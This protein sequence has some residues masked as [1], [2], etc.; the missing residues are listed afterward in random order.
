MELVRP[1]PENPS[2]QTMADCRATEAELQEMI[3]NISKEPN[4]GLRFEAGVDLVRGL[5]KDASLEGIQFAIH[6]A[7]QL[8]SGNRKF[9][10][11][12]C[13][14]A[15]DQM[16]VDDFYY[17]EDVLGDTKVERICLSV[18]LVKQRSVRKWLLTSLVACA[19]H[20]VN[21]E[22]WAGR[23]EWF[24]RQAEGHVDWA[25]TVMGDINFKVEMRPIEDAAGL[26]PEAGTVH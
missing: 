21:L 18:A 19:R 10:F 17:M 3:D 14:D 2:R 4:L 25:P 20:D 6:D 9:C 22:A 15:G 12:G 8:L 16:D 11:E 7:K 24:L 13:F 1:T 5:V 26:T 23:I